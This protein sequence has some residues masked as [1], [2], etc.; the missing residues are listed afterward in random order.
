MPQNKEDQGC[1]Y[2][3]PTK[4]SDVSFMIENGQEAELFS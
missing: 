2:L 3:N 1:F 4:H